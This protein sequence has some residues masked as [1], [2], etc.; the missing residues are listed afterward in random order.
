MRSQNCAL[1]LAL[2]AAAIIGISTCVPLARSQTLLPLIPYPAELKAGGELSLAH[3]VVVKLEG[4]DPNDRFAAFDLEKFLQQRAISTH[5]VT[6]NCV[7]IVL[8]RANTENGQQ[9]LHHAKLVFDA[10]MHDEG[11]VILAA[12]RT[13]DILAA[14][15]AGIFYGVQTV[16]Q[17]VH[18]HGPDA[19]LRAVTIRDWPAMPFRAIDDDLSRGPIPTLAYQKKQIRTFAAYKLNVYSPYFENALEHANTPITAPFGGGV[20]A[21]DVKELVAYA[22]QYHIEI[23]PE[24]EA[25][26]HLQGVLKYEE[27]SKLSETPHGSVLAPQQPGSLD[28]I[29]EWF[30]EMA[31]EFPS[32]FVHIG[33][34]EPF[35][36]GRGQTSDLV[37]RDKLGP[38]YIDFLK[39]IHAAL[40]PYGKRLL[41]WGD[42]AR[43]EPALLSSLPKDMI[44]MPWWYDPQPKGFDSYILPFRQAGMETWVAPG[45]NNW[46]RVYPNNDMAL[47]N[48]QGFV[49]DGQRLGATGV[50]NTV[51][52]DDG[53]GLFASDWYG[54]LFGAAAGWQKGESSIPQ[55][56]QSY[57]EV[58][59]GDSTGK[60]NQAQLELMAAHKLMQGLG[61]D[62]YP[63]DGSDAIFW[64][65]PWSREGQQLSLRMQPIVHDLR[66]HAERAID[67]VRE[68]RNKHDLQEP[69]A[70]EAL[71]LGAY[72]F[73]AIGL[74]FQAAAEI[75]KAYRNAY[76]HRA[77]SPERVHGER[78]SV[79]LDLMDISDIQGRCQDL[80]NSY[81]E[82]KDAYEKLWLKENRPYALGN[83]L[84]RYDMSI[85]LWT[86]RGDW[87]Q[88][89]L[90]QWQKTG[91]LPAPD[92]IGIPPGPPR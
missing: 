5:C 83:V 65:D 69:E 91:E 89:L 60:I 13:I 61:M 85:Q 71:E 32:P 48:I 90:H 80:R 6:Q 34:D 74:K 55:F 72:R 43:N 2:K 35:E 29:R 38:V 41:F 8:V 84:A 47:R 17:L 45:V 79:E 4:Y 9:L 21:A 67:L 27:F 10:D 82:S 22:K 7:S 57:G 33:A 75:S 64:I 66:M 49:R 19:R 20:T 73:D 36:L 68:T 86:A 92:E 53:E 46:D 88:S 42:I 30:G 25:F 1:K 28:L 54:V 44:A 11:Y 70:L 50:F 31:S 16:K 81:S 77:E 39:R 24:Q 59:H 87:F 52:N 15:D 40:Q 3:G 51:W 18:E 12:G 63:D 37:E 23:V 14:T 58:F 26:S 56:E 62:S 76:A 78:P